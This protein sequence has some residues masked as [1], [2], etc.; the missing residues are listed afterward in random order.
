[1]IKYLNIFPKDIL[2]TNFLKNVNDRINLLL[3]LHREQIIKYLNIRL[4]DILKIN[5]FLNVNRKSP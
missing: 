4:K 3:S 2:K 5:F 1:M